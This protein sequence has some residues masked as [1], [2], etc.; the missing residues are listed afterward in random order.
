MSVRQRIIVLYKETF[1]IKW[2]QG[3]LFSFGCVYDL[4]MRLYVP[5]GDNKRGSPCL[6]QDLLVIFMSEDILHDTPLDSF[7][8]FHNP[9]NSLA[10]VH[11]RTQGNKFLHASTIQFIFE[12]ANDL[13]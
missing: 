13:E 11:F 12:L 6:I 8:F 9:I 10:A 3:N 2:S 1:I 5:L 7:C 4:L